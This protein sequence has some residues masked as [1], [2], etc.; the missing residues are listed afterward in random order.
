MQALHDLSE[1]DLRSG[2]PKMVPLTTS[3]TLCSRLG[4]QSLHFF[5]ALG[6]SRRWLKEPVES[7]E[8]I[9]EYKRLRD[10]AHNV[11]VSNESTERMIKRTNDFKDYGSRLEEDFQATLQVV[12]QAIEQIPKRNSKAAIMQ[13]YGQTS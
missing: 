4:S 7:W 3:T 11:P 5:S 6:V 2:T 8:G 12:G 13:S 9:P 10:F 1:A